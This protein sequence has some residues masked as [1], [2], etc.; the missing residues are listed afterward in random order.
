MRTAMFL[1]IRSHHGVY[2]VTVFY[3][4]FKCLQDKAYSHWREVAC[5]GVGA[6][7]CLS[8]NYIQETLPSFSNV[9][10]T[11]E[12]LSAEIDVIFSHSSDGLAIFSA[13]IRQPQSVH[14]VDFHF[15]G[16][17][18]AVI[19]V[20][21]PYISFMRAYNVLFLSKRTCTG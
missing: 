6:S 10:S 5:I 8:L 17:V 2:V 21:F 14:G 19:R 1:P 16:E 9:A 20:T 11:F 13:S 15:L 3:Q 7:L 18:S 12:L 4:C